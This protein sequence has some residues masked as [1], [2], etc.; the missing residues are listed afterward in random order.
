MK[1]GAG[2]LSNPSLSRSHS[3]RVP[4]SA[5]LTLNGNWPL[6]FPAHNLNDKP[7]CNKLFL[8]LVTSAS[9]LSG[10]W[11]PLKRTRTQTAI[12]S[13]G[14]FIISW[15]ERCLTVIRFRFHGLSGFTV[16][17]LF[18][19]KAFGHRNLRA[20]LRQAIGRRVW[21]ARFTAWPSRGRH[22]W[23]GQARFCRGRTRLCIG[24]SR[25]CPPPAG[26]G[27]LCMANGFRWPNNRSRRRRRAG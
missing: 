6:W 14:V 23:A 17:S 19:A 4:P 25:V 3:S 27:C 5:W 26:A 8:E 15:G 18:P 21:R 20:Q 13:C 2:F 11:Q 9:L 22:R 1:T 24:G 10:L 12:N 16:S 7:I